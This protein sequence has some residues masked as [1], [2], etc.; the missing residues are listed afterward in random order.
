MVLYINMYNVNKFYNEKALQMAMSVEIA[1]IIDKNQ[2][3]NL[4]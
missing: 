3:K 2:R 4:T 1:F